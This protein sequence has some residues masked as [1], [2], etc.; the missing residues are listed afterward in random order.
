M[1]ASADHGIS[2]SETARFT[3]CASR[4]PR[5][6]LA[7]QASEL[8]LGSDVPG[9]AGFKVVF[10]AEP[11]NPRTPEPQNPRTPEPQHSCGL[12]EFF[13]ADYI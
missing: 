5:T 2:L 7:R 12:E 8:C 6:F 11:Q 9:Y 10:P 3:L 4:F 1:V 13:R